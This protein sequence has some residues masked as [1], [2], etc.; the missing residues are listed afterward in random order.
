MAITVIIG[1]IVV[2]TT[3]IVTGAVLLVGWRVRR[4]ERDFSLTR[5]APGHLSQGVRMLTGPY[6]RQRSDCP[7]ANYRPD[8]YV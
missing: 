6:V 2:F 3:G 7:V 4:E 5:Q 8:T 1:I